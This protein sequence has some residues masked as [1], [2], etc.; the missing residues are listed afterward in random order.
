MKHLLYCILTACPLRGDDL[1]TGTDGVRVSL[2][3]DNRLSAAYSV[4]GDS[5]ATP[6]ISTCV[7]YAR[8]IQEIHERATV[9]PMRY[10]CLLGSEQA[11]R[12]L[13]QLRGEYFKAALAE[14]EG[15]VEMGVR[16]LLPAAPPRARER[17]AVGAAPPSGTGYL[18]ARQAAYGA[19]DAD[20]HEAD[21]A[22]CAIRDALAP[23]VVK[24][25]PDRSRMGNRRA[26][27][28]CF[29]VRREEVAELREAFR[30][31]QEEADLKLLLS[32]PWPPYSFVH[33]EPCGRMA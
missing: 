20:C 12:E 27:S 28:I 8:V 3:T 10:G 26:A 6:D 30:R 19:M 21:A 16:V 14:L 31:F 5:C 4:L 18:A 9:V 11:V 22:I 2:L 29:L 13:L 1:P 15:C 32:G 33:A 24:S 7:A 25:N 17:V 23:Y